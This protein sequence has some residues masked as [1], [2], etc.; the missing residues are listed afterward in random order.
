MTI[1]LVFK[2]FYSSFTRLVAVFPT[3]SLTSERDGKIQ[4]ITESL[5]KYE[6]IIQ[7]IQYKVSATQRNDDAVSRSHH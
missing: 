3:V 7:D 1:S 6:E 2:D 5:Q 4:R